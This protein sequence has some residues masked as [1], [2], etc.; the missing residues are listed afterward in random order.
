MAHFLSICFSYPFNTQLILYGDYDI[1]FGNR[2]LDILQSHHIQ[3]FILKGGD[4][5]HNQPNDNGPNLKLVNMYG[6]SRMNRMRK[7]GTLKF[8]TTHTNSVLVVT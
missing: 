2:A 8:I 3:D 5:V 7:H 4:L 6:N 1:H